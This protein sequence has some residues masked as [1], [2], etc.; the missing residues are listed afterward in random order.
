[1]LQHLTT[2][3]SLYKLHNKDYVYP[4]EEIDK[5]WEKVLLNQCGTTFGFVSLL[6]GSDRFFPL[7]VQSMTVRAPN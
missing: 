7:F 3:A 4:K 6:Y 5:A 1:M 2:L